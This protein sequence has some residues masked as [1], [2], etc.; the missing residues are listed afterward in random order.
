VEKNKMMHVLRSEFAILATVCFLA[1]GCDRSVEQ[2][3]KKYMVAGQKHASAYDYSSALLDYRN[4]AKVDPKDPEPQYQAALVYLAMGD[5][6]TAIAALQSALVLNP[7][8]LPAALKMS[9]LMLATKDPATMKE[10]EARLKEFYAQMPNNPDVLRA[11][12]T[13]QLALGKLDEAETSLSAALKQLPNDPKANLTFALVKIARKDY[14]GAEVLLKQASETDLKSPDPFVALG[15]FATMM[16]RKAEAGAYFQ[17]ALE[18]DPANAEALLHTA[19]LLVE[20]GDKAGADRTYARLAANP[21]PQYRVMHAVYLADTGRSSDALTELQQL[22]QKDESD[23]NIRSRLVA[24]YQAAGRTEEALKVLTEALDRNPRDTDALLQR[25]ELSI[26][27]GKLVAAENDLNTTVKYRP[28]SAEAHVLLAQ[29]GMRRGQNLVAR[30]ELNLALGLNPSLLSARLMLAQSVGPENPKAALDILNAAPE[31]QRNSVE[32]ITERNAAL[33]AAGDLGPAEAGVIQGLK[34]SRT[35]DLLLQDAVLKL[36]NRNPAGARAALEEALNASPDDVKVLDALVATYVEE[37]RTGEGI[38]KVK[39]HISGRPTS[40][41]S[42][43]YLGSLLARNGDREGAKAAFLKAKQ[44]DGSL[45]SA[46]MELGRIAALEGKPTEARPLLLAAANASPQDVTARVMLGMLEQSQG[47]NK[48]AIEQYRKA[49]EIDGRNVLALNN[50]AYELSESENSVDE[51]LK[52]AQMAREL[53]PHP[54]PALEDTIGWIYYRKGVYQTAVRYLENSVKQEPSALHH[55]HL[56][57]AYLR[58]G[59]RELAEKSLHEAIRLNSNL[60]EVKAAV[61]TFKAE[62]K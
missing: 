7:K 44:I 45:W 5:P 23:R 30:Q 59:R 12:G 47:N 56:S 40:A 27:S 32:I 9:E 42:E 49:V 41:A 11:L 8:H 1:V 20:T 13:S 54:T 14:S 53:S 3:A 37:K 24:A 51:A 2:K 38:S 33:I 10:S 18:R 21:D 46:D 35:S 28:D 58:L 52:Y 39:E 26:R 55:S 43:F 31:A 57:V 16:G 50:L 29:L 6:S 4:A 48:I 25:A 36:R 34:L 22:N 61:A 60:P 62:R 19:S 17:K 15:K